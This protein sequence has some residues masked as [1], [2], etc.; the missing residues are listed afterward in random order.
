MAGAHLA[1]VCRSSWNR[2]A[3]IQAQGRPGPDLRLGEANLI[4]RPCSSDNAPNGC[5]PPSL[6]LLAQNRLH[7]CDNLS[8]LRCNWMALNADL[9]LKS[10]N[11]QEFD[12]VETFPLKFDMLIAETCSFALTENLHFLTKFIHQQKIR[13]S[14]KQ[15]K[16]P[17]SSSPFSFMILARVLQT[18]LKI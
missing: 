17:R 7:R 15:P 2:P 16:F 13:A 8:S 1:S 12:Q 6:F 9:G 14:F 4:C 11:V 3:R 10:R 18:S 5:D